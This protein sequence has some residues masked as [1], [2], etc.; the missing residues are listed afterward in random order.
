MF[1]R[2]GRGFVVARTGCEFGR[3]VGGMARGGTSC[4]YAQHGPKWPPHEESKES[5]SGFSRLEVT[6][7]DCRLIRTYIR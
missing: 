7:P 4:R 2:R 3:A 5:R 1:P 6:G